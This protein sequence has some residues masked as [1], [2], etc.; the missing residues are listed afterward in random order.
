MVKVV[1]I[2]NGAGGAGKDTLCE[3]VSAHLNSVNVSS[4]TPIKDIAGSYGWNGE[5]DEASR[6][7]LSDLKRTFIDFNNLPTEY[8][9]TEY[10]DFMNGP[11]V[12]FFAHV[13]EP[14]EIDKFKE[15]IQSPCVTLLIRRSENKS[16][17]NDSDDDVENYSYD[18]YFDND[19]AL[20][21]TQIEFHSLICKIMNEVG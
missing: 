7:F 6:K 21:E 20:D 2:I 8:L 5:K 3:Y 14:S 16:W 18:Y 15:R 11:A 19:K 17:G 10:A 12:V 1:I 4:I 9:L 13:R